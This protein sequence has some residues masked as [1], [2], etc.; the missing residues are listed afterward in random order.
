MTPP[1]ETGKE[2]AFLG[3][4]EFLTFQRLT[5]NNRHCRSPLP[6]QGKAPCPAPNTSPA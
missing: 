5:S 2:T 3:S 6:G 1:E 4:L